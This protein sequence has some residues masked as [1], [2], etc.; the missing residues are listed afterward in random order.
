MEKVTD[1]NVNNPK[2]RWIYV[3]LGILIMM[4]LGTVY[5]WSVI[6]SPIEELFNIGS[7]QSGLPYMTSL[8]FYAIFMLLSGKYLD[9]VSPRVTITIGSVLV[10]LGW[11]LSSFATN[12]YMLTL[13]YGVII[14]S[15]VG[16]AYGSPMTIVA[17]W[18]PENRG[19][20]VG[21]VLIGFGLSPLVTAPLLR[22][23]I[24]IKGVTDTFVILGVSFGIIMPL[25][26][27]PIKSPKDT[28]IKDGS[29]ASN[30]STDKDQVDTSRMIKSKG[31][32]GLYLSFLIG[33]MIGLMIIGMTS[34]VGVDMIG[35]D[36]HQVAFLMTIFAVFNGIGRPFYGWLTDRLSAKKA[37]FFS[38]VMIAVAAGI[39][40]AAGEGTTIRFL[41]GF[42]IFWFN[43]GGWLAIA[44][45]STLSMY[46][47]KHYSQNYG[48]VF[49]AYG[50]GAI[51]GVTGSGMLLDAVHDYHAVFYLI[52][53]LCILGMI[54]SQTLIKKCD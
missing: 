44:P 14:G 3:L 53:G 46:G 34:N 36:A 48:V 22:T 40:I 45:A 33:T 6:R 32:K 49:T 12:I 28:G 4:C 20:A 8:A 29:S 27:M 47:T 17:K 5:S 1:I 11:V 50:V 42:S 35:L 54:F 37:M 26:S 39:M 21:L 19:L 24:E 2:K 16:I 13:T 23:L 18:F 25:L 7:T 38:Y 15:G 51:T 30:Q 9:K 31:F 43:L 10:A 52:I 41:V